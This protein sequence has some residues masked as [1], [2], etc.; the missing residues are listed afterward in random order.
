MRVF[1]TG[2]TGHSGSYIIPEL[3]AAGHQ[4]TGLARSDAAAATLT[5]L[6]A[7]VRRGSLEDLD[8][9]KKAAEDSDGV[10]HVAHRQDLLPSG[11][12]DA[13]TAAEVPVI[14]AYGEALAGT[15]KP[16]VAAG[17]MAAPGNL[18]RPVTEEDPALPGGDEHKGTLRFRNAV[19]TAVVG[20]AE[21]GVRSSIV[22]LPTI[23][24]STTDRA[25]FL[26]GLI[27]LAQE[28][29]YAGYPG[30][31]ENLW[32]AVHIRDVASLFRLALEKGS[33]GNRWHAVADGSI[34][35]R[36]IAEAIGSR[37]GLPTVSVPVDVLMLPAYFG[38]FTIL[39]TMSVPASNVITRRTLGWEPVEPSLLAD[40][41]NGNY[42]SGRLTA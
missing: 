2:G 24:H 37:L 13:V 31:G 12:I 15:G 40:L 34:P 1:V 23:A 7:K 20:L 42:F 11:G 17:S 9:L 35:F 8:G 14:L 19:E 10:I 25:G 27:A 30:D 39:V 38:M 18:G 36:E 32:G 16:L 3:I 41:D 5:A 26:P 6:G 21:R 4:V 29:G 28:K 22:R 33:A